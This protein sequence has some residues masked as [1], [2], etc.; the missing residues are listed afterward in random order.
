MMGPGRALVIIDLQNDFLPGGALPVPCGNEIVAVANH[1]APLFELVVATQDWHP[2]DHVSFAVNHAGRRPGDVIDVGG[3]RQ[4]L[5]PVHCVQGSH[6]AAL[7][8][9]LN[10]EDI[11]RII[12]KGTDSS[13]DSYSAFFDNTR[14]RATGLEDFLRSANVR[15]L[16]LLG[17][18]TEYCVAY[19]AL[20]ALRLGFTVWIVVDG[21]RGI[22]LTPGDAASALKSLSEGGANLI[23]S[24]E[25]P[26]LLARDFGQH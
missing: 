10:A 11:T 21:C 12:Q 19:S 15:Q 1:V 22:D 7:A 16:F 26:A 2:A 24:R 13:V 9:G 23:H 14:G 4:T 3:Q 20:D 8:A 6:G 25:L 18:A 5:W 17:L